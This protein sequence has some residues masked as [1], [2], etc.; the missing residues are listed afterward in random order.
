MPLHLIAGP[1]IQS[2][3][4]ENV[5]NNLTYQVR[6]SFLRGHLIHLDYHPSSLYL[7]MIKDT[8]HRID[9]AIWHAAPFKQLH[10]FRNRFRFEQLV[11]NARADL[12]VLHAYG[13][14][15]ET[16]IFSELWFP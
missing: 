9:A 2:V 12:A 1:T 6:R 13:V 10:P 11:D 16:G 15:L 14:R 7:R 5:Q 8:L 3:E 4:L